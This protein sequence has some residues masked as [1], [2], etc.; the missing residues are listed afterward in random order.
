MFD[1]RAT[2]GRPVRGGGLGGAWKLQA[3]IRPPWEEMNNFYV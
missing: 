2:G 3:R 1:A